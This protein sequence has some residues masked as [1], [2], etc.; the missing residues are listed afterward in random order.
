MD[1]LNDYDRVNRFFDLA[2]R[3]AKSHNA[4]T[5]FGYAARGSCAKSKVGLPMLREAEA[6]FQ[7][8]PDAMK[9]GE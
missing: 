8:S 1:T 7:S 4:T 9:S 3:A 2:V 5:T 6:I